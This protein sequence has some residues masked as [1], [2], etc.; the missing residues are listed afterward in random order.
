MPGCQTRDVSRAHVSPDHMK[1]SLSKHSFS[2]LGVIPDRLLYSPSQLNHIKLLIETI[3]TINKI[4]FMLHVVESNL[5]AS[6][7]GIN[8]TPRTFFMIF[9]IVSF[10][11]F[12]ISKIK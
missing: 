12:E 4:G 3:N 10:W 11:F 7:S 2:S 9:S 1:T 8:A 6:S 5:P